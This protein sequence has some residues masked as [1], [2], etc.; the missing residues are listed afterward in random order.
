MSLTSHVICRHADTLSGDTGIME[1]DGGWLHWIQQNFSVTFGSEGCRV[2]SVQ[3][4][5]AAQCAV[6]QLQFYGSFVSPPAAT[7]RH[8]TSRCWPGIEWSNGGFIQIMP[9]VSTALYLDPGPPELGF[10]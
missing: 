2:Q 8:T 1:A 6:M 5:Q 4:V 7:Q 10:A 3:S 9:S